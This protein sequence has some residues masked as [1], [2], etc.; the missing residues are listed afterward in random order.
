MASIDESMLTADEVQF[1]HHLSAL[2]VAAF[3]IRSDQM[4][5]EPDVTPMKLQKLLYLAQANYLA[6]TGQR[7]FDADVEAF[8]NGPVVYRVW[9][10]YAHHGGQIIAPDPAAA[11]GALPADVEEF[12]AGVW[13]RYQDWSASALRRLTHEQDPWRDHYDGSFRRRIPDDDMTSFFRH[14]VPVG[15]RV[16][17]ANVVLVTEDV[18]EDDEDADRRLREFLTA[19]PGSPG[20][21]SETSATWPRT[22]GECS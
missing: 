2:D 10:A 11:A 7:L 6:S 22:P 20:S 1:S 14:R 19:A 9:Q 3:Y 13:T 4:R 18:F 15:Q 5:D 17:H 12:L 8:D 21:R 16:R